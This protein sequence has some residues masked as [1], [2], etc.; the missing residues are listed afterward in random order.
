MLATATT[1]T[2]TLDAETMVA[3]TFAKVTDTMLDPWPSKFVPEMVTTV[4]TCPMTGL[5]LLMV[6]AAV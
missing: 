2:C 3:D 4:P 1:T 6:E 5:T